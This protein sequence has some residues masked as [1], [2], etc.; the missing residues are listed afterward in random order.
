MDGLGWPTEAEAVAN[1]EDL[2]ALTKNE[3]DLQEALNPQSTSLPNRRTVLI[4]SQS[5]RC[6][7]AWSDVN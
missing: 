3:F 6:W 4:Y 7:S 1:V 5:V 2:E